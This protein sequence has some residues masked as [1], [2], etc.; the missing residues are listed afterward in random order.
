MTKFWVTML[1]LAS[2]LFVAPAIESGTEV[3]QSIASADGGGG[4]G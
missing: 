3:F 4:A 1:V 2:F